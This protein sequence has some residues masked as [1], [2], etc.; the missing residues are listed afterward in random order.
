MKTRY[1]AIV[2]AILGLISAISPRDASAECELALALALDVS[3][4]VDAI[5]Y[6]LQRDGLAAA[7]ASRP[8]QDLLFAGPDHVAVAVY[9]WSGRRQQAMVLDWTPLLDRQV[10]IDVVDTITATQRSWDDFPTAMGHA[11]AYGAQMMARAPACLRQVIDISG[12]GVTNDGFDPL[13]AYRHFDFAD[14]VINGLVITTSDHRVPIYYQKEVIR[15]PGSFIELASGY[16]DFERAMRRKLTRE[17]GS[18][19]IGALELDR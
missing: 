4:S 19:A 11:L 16:E 10:L 9:E 14:T 3:S 17:I 18:L 13:T 15:G 1:A 8:V 6:R 5:E 2:G 7:L 12:D